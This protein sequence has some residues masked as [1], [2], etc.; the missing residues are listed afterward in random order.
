M[1][2]PIYPLACV[3]YECLTG[4][5]PFDEATMAGLVAA[6]LNSA[7]T[8]VDQPTERSAAVRRGD[9]HRH[10][11][12]PRSPVL[13]HRR[14]SHAAHD[15]IT[16]PIPRPTPSPP[17]LPATEP[18]SVPTAG[19]TVAAEDQIPLPSNLHALAPTQQRP[20]PQS[21]TRRREPSMEP[22]APTQPS[23]QWWRR[24]AVLI[25]TACV[26][27]LVAVVVGVT[28]ATTKNQPHGQ[29]ASP[30]T[31][32]SRLTTAGNQPPSQTAAP[33]TAEPP[34]RLSQYVTDRADALT[35]SAATDVESAIDK[36]YNNRGIRLWVVYVGNFGGQEAVSGAQSTIETTDSSDRCAILAVATVDRAYAF[37]VRA[38]ISDIT[39]S[40]V[41]GLRRNK[42]EPLL[43]LN[44][45]SGAAVAAAN[46]LDS[47]A[48]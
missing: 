39:P 43:R 14:V 4:R 46:G 28:L 2:A 37:L 47:A 8:A 1:P 17:P 21:P 19:P 33:T 38:S 5:P 40:Q 9:R 42:I 15:A 3:L 12:R 7:A 48:G 36:L 31:S 16:G 27:T 6:H 18:A 11:Q 22:A 13:D 20:P 30:T 23:R 45:F 32:E 35:E 44:D 41:D 29:T 34:F 26:V 24:K 10:G 25:S